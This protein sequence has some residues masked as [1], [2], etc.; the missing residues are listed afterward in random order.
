MAQA[1]NVVGRVIALQGQAFVR[2]PDGH[3]RQLQLNDVVHEGEVIVT[4]PGGQVEL[5]FASGKTYLIHQNETAMLDAA[6]FAADAP[7]P[8]DAALFSQN[9][10]INNVTKAIAAGNSLDALLDE[11]AAGLTGGGG[12]NSSHSFVQ[13]MRVA[14]TVAPLN[15]QFESTERVV[16]APQA[17]EEIRVPAPVTAQATAPETTVTPVAPTITLNPITG[18]NVLNASEISGTVA[19]T[20]SVGGGAQAGDTVAL[21]VG[22]KTYTGQ[23]LAD[24]S[25]SI[26]VP[27][28]DMTGATSLTATVTSGSG[29]T[30]TSASASL[31]YTVDTA[32]A[33]SITIDPVS[34][35]NVVNSAEAASSVTITGTVGGDAKAGDIVTLSVNGHSYSGTVHADNAYAINVSG[36]DLAAAGNVSA[37]VTATDAAG[38]TATASASHAYGVDLA[39][40]ASIAIDPITGD[41]IINAAERGGDVI[42]VTGTVGGD[43]KVDDVVTLTVGGGT[44]TGHVVD[45]GDG[46][47][48]FSIDVGSG[49]LAENSSISASITASDAAGNTVTASV[50]LPYNNTPVATTGAVTTEENSVLS[51]QVPAA[52]DAD[53]AIAGYQLVDSVGAGNG[54]LTF[55]ADGT[56][57]F[58]PG[59]DFDSLA[60]GQSREVSFTYA[61]TDDKGAVSEPA[62]VTIT[63]TGTNDVPVAV[64][65]AAT[66]AENSV[67]EGHVPAASD[68]DGTIASYQLVD[69]VGSGNGALTFN[70]DGTYTFNPGSDFDSLAAGQSRD[71]SFTYTAT[72]NNGAVS[73]AQTVTIT[74]TGTNDAPVATNDVLS[75]NEDT[76]ATIDPATL[77]GN[78]TDVDGDKLTISSV[79]D[80]AHGTVALVDGKVVF[81]PE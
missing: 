49:D 37:S 26:D 18:D 63:V 24:H 46:K 64:A 48:S 67:L 29:S 28:A 56:Y 72:D 34:A 33:A 7:A 59:S 71:V 53:G 30:A 31:G 66:T 22:G 80:A 35:D 45:L 55:N 16:T 6:V 65:A 20:G 17:T 68:V 75:T 39:A 36:A 15:I 78:D 57:S 38:N 11:T 1:N 14:E 70:Q 25:Y 13:L 32:A 40:A 12:E 52:S 73:A 62:I 74:V 19:V 41:N 27:G 51:G 58:N 43:A 79:Q 2:T 60:A 47:L 3:Q 77:L 10:E 76:P 50:E 4:A 44:Y 9:T 69:G 81:T 61:A 21:T 54:S 42:T 5:S 23:V 8:A